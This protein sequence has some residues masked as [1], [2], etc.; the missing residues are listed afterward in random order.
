[1]IWYMIWYD[2]EVMFI[3]LGVWNLDEAPIFYVFQRTYGHT[4]MKVVIANTNPF[5][6]IGANFDRF[7]SSLFMT[8]S[9][10]DFFSTYMEVQKLPQ[11]LLL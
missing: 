7:S 4:C 10:F 5:L 3:M 8:F 11:I 2:D 6:N 9:R 1:M